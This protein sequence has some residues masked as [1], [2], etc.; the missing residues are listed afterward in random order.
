MTF[1]VAVLLSRGRARK[2]GLV[3]I[4]VV[5]RDDCDLQ[6]AGAVRNCSGAQDSLARTRAAA[7]ITPLA[8]A[9]CSTAP[10]FSN[11]FPVVRLV[12]MIWSY[13]K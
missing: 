6:I 13:Q 10:V 5:I 3:L 1:K 12:T 11:C 9:S 2:V 8:F 4:I 7:G